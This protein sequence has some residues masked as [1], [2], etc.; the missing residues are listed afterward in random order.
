MVYKN[1]T[2]AFC[3]PEDSFVVS[4]F[5]E[6]FKFAF[7][8][9]SL[10]H[11]RQETKWGESWLSHEMF[12]ER[13]LSVHPKCWMLISHVEAKNLIPIPEKSNIAMGHSLWAH[14]IRKNKIKRHNWKKK[15]SVELK[16]YFL[17]FPWIEPQYLEFWFSGRKTYGLDNTDQL[18]TLFIS[19]HS[20]SSPSSFYFSLRIKEKFCNWW[21]YK[22]KHAYSLKNKLC[23]EIS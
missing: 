13:L 7:M 22:Y 15:R 10:F 14:C 6:T 2:C 9:I 18:C 3:T 5:Q 11:T 17:D 16:G 20:F 1:Y 4:N 21:N 23:L 19:P 8:T 12:F